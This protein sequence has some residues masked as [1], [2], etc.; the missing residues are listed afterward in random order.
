MI[1]M[2]VPKLTKTVKK[3][4]FTIN[5]LILLVFILTLAIIFAGCQDAGNRSGQEDLTI[6]EEDLNFVIHENLVD[7]MNEK[8]YDSLND[9][10]P[11]GQN[12]KRRLY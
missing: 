8:G 9:L 10:Q 1:M 12:L 4:S 11:Q 7:R 3:S 6:S 5:L 2:D